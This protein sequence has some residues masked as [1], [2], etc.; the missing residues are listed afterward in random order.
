M[1]VTLDTN[2][3]V[4]GTFWEGEA[5]R[6]LELI[7]R[8]RVQCV[9]SKGILAEYDRIMHSDEILEKVDEKRLQ[10]RAIVLK[11][12]GMCT[13]VQPKRKIHAVLED[14][15]DDKVIECAVEGGVDYIVTY[16]AKHL[17]KLGEFEGILIVSPG[18]FLKKFGK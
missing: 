13:V 9:L 15:D 11:V 14:P 10:I 5:F 17:L 3:L 1:K 7:E 12:V 6:I 18:D 2:V 4:S 8:K 16:D